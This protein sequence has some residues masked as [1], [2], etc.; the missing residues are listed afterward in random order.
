MGALASGNF[1]GDPPGEISAHTTLWH[2]WFS[3]FPL[4]GE[5]QNDSL[6]STST[7]EPIRN[8]FHFNV[9]S[10]LAEGRLEMEVVLLYTLPVLSKFELSKILCKCHVIKVQT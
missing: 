2:L 4:S 7:G 3:L 5:T 9:W 1:L 8:I 10:L 6:T